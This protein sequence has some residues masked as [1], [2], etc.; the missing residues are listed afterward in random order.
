MFF[1]NDKFLKLTLVRTFINNTQ[2]NIA[3][4]KRTCLS[5]VQ[6]KNS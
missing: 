4:F 6:K 1:V 3:A 2:T 5:I